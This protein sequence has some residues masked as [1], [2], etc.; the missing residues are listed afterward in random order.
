MFTGIVETTVEV[1]SLKTVEKGRFRGK[2]LRIRLP[3]QWEVQEGQSVS[4]NGCCL[5]VCCVECSAIIFDLG[6]ETLKCT[7]L[8]L[9]QKNSSVNVERAM[10]IS[11][12]FDGHIV[13]GHVDGMAKV[14]CFKNGEQGSELKIRI[15]GELMSMVVLKG[16][17]CLNG[18]SLTVNKMDDQNSESFLS[19]LLIPATLEWTNFQL[20]K[21]GDFLNIE[22]DIMGKHLARCFELKS[23]RS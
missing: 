5:T 10:G 22:M 7:N 9:L 3:S 2:S 23:R 18:V 19:F 14:V 11:D 8:S 15:P 6:K 21:P 13:T 16:S 4:V 17:V 20:I 1:V 12:R